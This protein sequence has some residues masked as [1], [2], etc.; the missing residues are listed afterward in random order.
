MSNC[1]AP[2]R[3]IPNCEENPLIPMGA[4]T[5]TPTRE[6][7][8]ELLKNWRRCGVTQF[9]IYPRSGLELE[10]MSEAWLDRCEWICEDAQALG[11]TSIWLYDERNWPSGTCNGEVLKRNPDHAIRALCV[12]EPRPGEYEFHLRRGSR[13]ADLL[14]P[15]A[16]DSFLRLTHERYE[17]RLGRFFGTLIKGFFTDEPDIAFFYELYDRLF[18]S[19]W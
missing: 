5:G 11:F 13:M 1:R 6:F 17:K 3:P 14:D 8:Y 18:F 16:V 15:D 9:M 4:I 7:L 19:F 12:S 10:H 2:E